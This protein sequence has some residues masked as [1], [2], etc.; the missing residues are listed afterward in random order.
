[1][2]LISTRDKT[3]P[4]RW[5]LTVDEDC[6][7]F[8]NGE[9]AADFVEKVLNDPRGW[10]SHGYRFVR[11]NVATG[12]RLRRNKND[13]KSVFH[14]RISKDATIQAECGFSGLS[15][16]DMSK[17]TILLNLSRWLH[18]SEASG[19]DL[20]SYRY[21][22]STHEIGH[23]L[24]RSHYSCSAYPIDLCPIMYQQTIS[25]SCCKPNHLL[26]DWE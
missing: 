10:I 13:W 8:V 16:A 22:V 20:V 1:M 12:L 6:S 24:G 21:Y 3:F 5:F 7:P 9:E 17:N 2:T 23:L 18:G 11:I 14:I 4:R 25:K 26:L 15:C 19:L